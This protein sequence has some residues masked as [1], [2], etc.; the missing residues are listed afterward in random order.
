MTKKF[1]FLLC[2]HLQIA[3]GDKWIDVKPFS[4]TAILPN[5]VIKQKQKKPLSAEH[6]SP[7]GLSVV[8]LSKQT[9]FLVFTLSLLWHQIQKELSSS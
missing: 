1:V 2:S 4:S 6:W 8:V 7:D 9:K 3:R 5:F